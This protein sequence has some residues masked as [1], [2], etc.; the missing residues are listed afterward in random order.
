MPLLSK[1]PKELPII[2]AKEPQIMFIGKIRLQEL[3]EKIMGMLKDRGFD[4]SMGKY[5]LKGGGALKELEVKIE[6]SKKELD[7]LEYSIKVVVHVLKG[8]VLESTKDNLYKVVQGR[9]EITLESSITLDYDKR[10]EGSRYR[11]ILGR[12]YWFIMKWDI[13]IKADKYYYDCLSIIDSIKKE[14][15]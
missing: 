8:K 7:F 11:D 5:K 9:I 12:I 15:G 14:L 1:F 2:K 6:G 4:I 13:L 3:L 10:Y